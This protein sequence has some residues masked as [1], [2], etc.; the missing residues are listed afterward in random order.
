MQDGNTHGPRVG[1]VQSCTIFGRGWPRSKMFRRM[2]RNTH[3]GVTTT[4]QRYCHHVEILK[5]CL[6]G[7]NHLGGEGGLVQCN[8]TCWRGK[9]NLL[10]YGLYH[11]PS[12]EGNRPI[13][14]F[15]RRGPRSNDQ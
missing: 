15:E 10:R 9:P 12:K 5:Y 11:F 1:V 3:F 2:G 6:R 14:P 8:E 13:G 7:T 4:N